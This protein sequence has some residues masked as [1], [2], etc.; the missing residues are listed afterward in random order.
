MSKIQP[1]SNSDTISYADKEVKN[2]W[3]KK[4]VKAD[5]INTNQDSIAEIERLLALAHNTT[6]C[7]Q[8][9]L[10]SEPRT[11]QALFAAVNRENRVY[12]LT[13][14]PSEELK[15]LYGSCL[16]RYGINNIGSFILINPNSNAPQGLFFTGQLT[17]GSLL[18]KS[19][20]L[21]NL[22]KEQS[23]ILYRHFCYHF[24][25]TARFEILDNTGNEHE[26]GNSPIDVYPCM[27]N[28]CDVGYIQDQLKS[29]RENCMVITPSIIN[30]EYFDFTGLR[31]SMFITSLSGNEDAVLPRI[32]ESSNSI[33]ANAEGILAN[34]IMGKDGVWIIPK[35]I[36]GSEDIFYALKLNAGQQNQ[37]IGLIEQYKN[38]ANYEYFNT[39]KRGELKN[40]T[41]LPLGSAEHF[42]IKETD[43]K[44][45]GDIPQRVLLSEEEMKQVR[46]NE[47][48]DDGTAVSMNYSWRVVPFYLPKESKRHDSYENWK[49]ET[50][51]IKNHL[52]DIFDKIK[53]SEENKSFK[54][55][56]AKLFLG[57]SNKFN[58]FKNKITELQNKQFDLIPHNE[59]EKDIIEINDIAKNVHADISELN[60]ADRIAQIEIAISEINRKLSDEK[61]HLE[62]INTTIAGQEGK[63]KLAM[64]E[65][66]KK[67]ELD[68]N[69][70]SSIRQN[71]EKNA[72]K[73]NKKEHPAEAEKA[74]QLLKELNG[75]SI[76]FAHKYK[77]DIRK[78]EKV[79]KALEDDKARKEQEKS[80]PSSEQKS[81]GSALDNITNSKGKKNQDT[82]TNSLTV[83][84][85]EPL[86]SV[87]TLYQ[88]N[89]LAYLA[90]KAYNDFE[91]GKDEAKRLNAKLCA[92]RS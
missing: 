60:E 67:N 1:V 87:G 15:I 74:E 54:E 30:K 10:L 4:D 41:I 88:L 55:R 68:E 64:T 25:N 45:L 33:Y 81:G 71:L 58:I 85:L 28:F 9:E 82:K 48:P 38:H 2:S 84:A 79:I 40:D 34:I 11:I 8:S 24:W 66:R 39:K 44:N 72:G 5:E 6:I 3:L 51:R 63:Q 65:F 78:I 62:E 92:E 35:S 29:Q 22:D 13:N 53:K 42:T 69:N 14:G 52:D 77:E 23:D 61:K 83:P 90:I 7:V 73:N 47:F 91:T 50:V 12:I 21:L 56:V 49:K 16:M 19:N 80:R 17:E 59:L 31:N 57:K 75:I 70:L 18:L 20:I 76:D 89:N 37:I 46:P 27:D 43:A 32:K 36:I 26:T 86:S